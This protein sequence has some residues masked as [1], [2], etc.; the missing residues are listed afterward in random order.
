MRTWWPS[1]R[2]AIHTDHNKADAPGAVQ[3]GSPGSR[4][5]QKL[6]VAKLSIHRPCAQ[7]CL[8]LEGDFSPSRA[9]GSEKHT[10]FPKDTQPV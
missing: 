2:V 10:D 7:E 3:P 1:V 4:E 8:P 6:P 9:Q 5:H